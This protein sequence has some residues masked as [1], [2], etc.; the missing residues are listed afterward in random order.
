METL[1]NIIIKVMKKTA[2]SFL[3]C[4]MFICVIG[5]LMGE[6]LI[7]ISTLFQEK[8]IGYS[9]IIEIFSLSFIIA[10]INVIF[11]IPPFMKKM[12]LIYKIILRLIVVITITVSY[13]YVFKWFPFT[14]LEAWVG[15]IVTF[16]ICFSLA[17]SISLYTTRKKNQE[18]QALLNDYKKRGQSYGRH[19]H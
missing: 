13:I 15:F 18:Y 10:I 14:S 2:I 6:Q 9:T 1:I 5:N 12:L 4:I 17:L 7:P 16:G 19:S 3:V 11:D 8:S